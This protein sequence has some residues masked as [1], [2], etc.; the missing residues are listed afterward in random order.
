MELSFIGFSSPA[1]SSS[2]LCSET[3][4]A[5]NSGLQP[6][7][8]AALPPSE[9]WH[10]RV[11]VH[12]AEPVAVSRRE[13]VEALL[14]TYAAPC[15]AVAISVVYFAKSPSG[16]STTERL[17]VSA[18]GALIACL[19]A[20]AICVAMLQLSELTWATPWTLLCLLPLASII[21]SLVRFRGPRQTHLLQI[22][23]CLCLAWTWLFGG[24]AITG[25]FV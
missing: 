13:M 21:Y 4:P 7:W 2:R 24:M 16:Q 1:A 22:L 20:V 25:E 3:Y 23:N 19:F 15:L 18:H 14:Q 9:L 6:T 12:A 17:L 11:A 10:H 8:A 5:S